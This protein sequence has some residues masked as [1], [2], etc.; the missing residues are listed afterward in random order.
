MDWMP[1][2]P[3]FFFRGRGIESRMIRQNSQGLIVVQ[4]D[5]PMFYCSRSDQGF[6]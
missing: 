1:R 5:T 4:D 3:D 6:W 2:V